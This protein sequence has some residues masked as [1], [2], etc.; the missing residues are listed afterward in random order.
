MFIFVIFFSN[1]FLPFFV[2]NLLNSSPILFCV[3]NHIKQ[4]TTV[5]EAKKAKYCSLLNGHQRALFVHLCLLWI[6][7]FT[8]APCSDFPSVFLLCRVGLAVNGASFHLFAVSVNPPLSYWAG[9]SVLPLCQWKVVN[10]SI[11]GQVMLC[12]FIFRS[13]QSKLYILYLFYI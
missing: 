6:P 7:V 2:C 12:L 8:R 11:R 10:T 3:T 5:N 9:A 1:S 13:T 4:T